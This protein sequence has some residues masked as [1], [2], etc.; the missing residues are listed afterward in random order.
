MKHSPSQAKSVSNRSLSLW[1]SHFLSFFLLLILQ[2]ASQLALAQEADAGHRCG[3]IRFP[4]HYG[5]FDYRNERNKLSIVEIAHF[6]PKV[7]AL[8]GSETGDINADI[9][10]TLLASPNHHRALITV[11]KL[12]DRLK[13]A[14]IQPSRFDF[15]LECYFDRA[16]RFRPD[17]H[18]ARLIF[19][20]TLAKL[21][22]IDEGVAQVD[23]VLK[24]AA[25]NPFTHYNAGLILF[26]LKQYDKALAEAHIAK[27]LG[28]PKAD[29]EQKLKQIN[30]WREPN[31]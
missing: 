22:R 10:Y 8:L 16:I 4:G 20:E 28:F 19:A 29:L 11:S 15:P 27:K 26:E 13:T 31:E 6:T 1:T 7:E 14:T 5:P 17:D 9:N 30:Q 12:I 3:P 23:V 21:N 24:L 25:D 18:I 2:V